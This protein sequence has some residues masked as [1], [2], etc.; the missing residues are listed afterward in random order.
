MHPHPWAI[1]FQVELKRIGDRMFL[2]RVVG[3]LSD[4]DGRN[5]DTPAVLSLVRRRIEEYAEIGLT[6][7]DRAFCRQWIFVRFYGEGQE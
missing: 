2:D 7:S 4:L 5:W 1:L 3:P 6:R